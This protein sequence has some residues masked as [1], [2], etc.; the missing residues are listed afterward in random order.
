MAPDGRIV[1]VTG[2][3]IPGNHRSGF[4][5]GGNI[6][7]AVLP[8]NAVKPGD[9]WWKTYDEPSPAFGGTIHV[10]TRSTYLRDESFHGVQAAVV[11]TAST[12]TISLD[13]KAAAATSTV[14]LK[15]TE[16]SDARSWIDP[17]THRLL[18]TLMP[19]SDTITLHPARPP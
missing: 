12:T 8:D 2:V 6:A 17:P 1:S 3:T 7:S 10:T 15:V 14:G 16:A 19:P 11:E 5:L 13:S 4:G 9:T 18:K